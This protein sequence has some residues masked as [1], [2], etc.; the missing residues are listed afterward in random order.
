[1]KEFIKN[2]NKEIYNLLQL[3]ILILLYAVAYNPDFILPHAVGEYLVAESIIRCSF[4]LFALHLTLR[5]CRFLLQMD[6][7]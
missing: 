2:K 1:M 5:L 7:D 6:K 4:F 3:V